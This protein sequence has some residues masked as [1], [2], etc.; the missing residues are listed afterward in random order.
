MFPL[1]TNRV[2]NHIHNGIRETAIL[3]MVLGISAIQTSFGQKSAARQILTL[4]VMELNKLDLVGGPLTLQIVGLNEDA[5]QP[6]PVTDANT[7][8][9]WTSNGDT[10]KIAVASN[11]TSPKF[12]LKIE[13]EKTGT[14]AWTPEPEV[15]LSDNAPHDLVVGV[16][17]SSGSC[18]LKVTALANVEAGTGSEQHLITYTITGS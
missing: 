1:K 13:A 14:G 9:Y 17:R 2:Q 10:R 7:K 18:T 16:E 8:L 6:S 4:Q 11:I 5:V 12:V 15:T 3:I